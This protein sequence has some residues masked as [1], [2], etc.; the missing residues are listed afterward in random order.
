MP[1][2]TVFT[3]Q[4]FVDPTRD[5]DDTS[6]SGIGVENA[7]DD[8]EAGDISVGGSGSEDTPPQEPW[9]SDFSEQVTKYR[10]NK[11]RKTKDVTSRKCLLVL[12]II[13]QT[14]FSSFVAA[15]ETGSDFLFALRF[16]QFSNCYYLL[17]LLIMPFDYFYIMPTLTNSI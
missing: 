8:F 13:N 7:S 4:G 3:P 15:S 12:I 14:H 11:P 16:T 17:R 9:A 5:S 10:E 6:S 2:N 1:A